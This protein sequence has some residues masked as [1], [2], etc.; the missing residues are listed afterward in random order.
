MKS[1]TR[2][3]WLKAGKFAGY[4]LGKVLVALLCVYLGILA[5]RTARNSSEIY[6]VAKDV[7]AKRTSVILTPIDN[8]DTDLLEGLFTEEYLEKSG[9]STQNT[10]SSYKI[11][12]YDERTDVTITVVFA[13]QNTA[14]IRVR[15]VVQDISAEISP[16]VVTTNEVDQFIESGIYTLYLVKDEAGSWKVQDLV[17]EEMIVPDSVYPI[18]T[19]DS[20]ADDGTVQEP[21]ESTEVTED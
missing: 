15:N 21:V 7:F 3:N 12:S 17:L 1:K 5:F 4:L 9:L 18:P 8:E 6:F 16:S 20:A 10:N 2:E 13:W 19:L 11:N 14:K